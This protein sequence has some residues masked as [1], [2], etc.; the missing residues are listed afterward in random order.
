MVDLN[1]AIGSEQGGVRPAV[2]VQN[3]MGN[4]HSP[5]TIICPLTSKNKKMLPTHTVLTPVDCGIT[6]DS[7]V[8]CEQVRAIS[9]ERLK[10]RLGMVSNMEKLEDINRKMIISLGLKRA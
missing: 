5:T 6:K 7:V 2:I 3:E 9:K 10:K 8:L 1:D 4:E